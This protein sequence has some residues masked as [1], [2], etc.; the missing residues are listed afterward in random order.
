MNKDFC[1]GCIYFVEKDNEYFC[2]KLHKLLNKVNYCIE[3]NEIEHLNMSGID[4]E[5]DDEINMSGV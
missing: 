2:D 5:D 4:V 1:D 3:Q